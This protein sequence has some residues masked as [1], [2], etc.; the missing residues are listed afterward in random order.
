[1]TENKKQIFILSGQSNMAGRGGIVYD[2]HHHKKHWNGVVP[3]ECQ[4]N[5][6][7]LR[8][9][10][11][12]QWEVAREPLHVDI[13]YKK[14]CGVGPGMA[15]ANKVMARVGD[16][17]CVTLGLVPC[18]VGGTQISE[19]ARGAELYEN[20][21]KRAKAAVEGED[22]GGGIKAVLWYQGESDCLKECDVVVYK[23]RM[24]KFVS[25]VREDLCLP[26]LPI[27]QVALASGDAKYIE[28][29]REAQLGITLPNV[30]CVD[31]K[32]LKLNHDNL[33]LTTEAQVQLGHMLADAYL[34][35]FCSSSLSSPDSK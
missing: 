7:I 34:D 6:S 16:G 23:E 19:W 9:N 10:A 31:A 26:L 21:V 3:P 1:M 24:E 32:G 28:R 5:P 27:I 2:T 18:A 25:D 29:I 8:L 11:H 15:F 22:G 12:L 35:N 4:P 33:H 13:D 20:M 17:A 14:A 30:V